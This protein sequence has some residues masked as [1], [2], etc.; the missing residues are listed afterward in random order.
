MRGSTSLNRRKFLNAIVL[1]QYVPSISRIYLAWAKI[2]KTKTLFKGSV[3]VARASFNLFLY[4][5]ASHVRTQ[6]QLQYVYYFASL[7]YDMCSRICWSLKDHD[8]LV[9]YVQVLGAFWFFFSVQ[10][11]TA[12]WHIACDNRIGCNPHFFNCD[13]GF[14]NYTF[15]ND[16]CPFITPNKTLFD[17][18]I[19]L[20]ALQSGTVA[21]TTFPR[22]I[23]YCFWWGVRNLR[24]LLHLY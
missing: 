16:Y 2:N 9:S 24:F 17:Y 5:L 8:L 6:V 15:L 12:C 10:R 21:S 23:M 19:F 13:H 7:C 20:E 11:Q 4:I 3:L 18:G 1:F 14:G 22:K